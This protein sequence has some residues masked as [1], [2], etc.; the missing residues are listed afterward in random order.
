[1]IHRSLRPLAVMLSVFASARLAYGALDQTTLLVGMHVFRAHTAAA[2]LPEYPASARKAGHTGRVTADVLVSPQ[3]KVT[4]VTIIEAPDEA[5]ADSVK[6]A[7]GRWVFGSFKTKDYPGTFAV[8]GRLIFY[9]RLE[10]G[11]PQ[12]IDAAAETFANQARSPQK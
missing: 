6:S 2:A 5:I 9:F 10:D 3:G 8:K 1:M 12:V 11:K 4:D 7:V